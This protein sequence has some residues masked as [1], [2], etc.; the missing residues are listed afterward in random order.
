MGTPKSQSR[1]PKHDV[2]IHVNNPQRHDVA[3]N[4]S[5][6]L[7][8]VALSNNLRSRFNFDLTFTAKPSS[9]Y[10]ICDRSEQFDHVI[11][12]ANKNALCLTNHNA[13]LNTKN[14]MTV[15]VTKYSRSP[16]TKT[17]ILS[18]NHVSESTS[19]DLT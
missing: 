9:L 8:S 1:L 16:F 4:L 19:P 10:S 18:K 6:L 12:L 7:S 14:H 11:K 13:A 15:K 2:T 5:I 3:Y 17:C